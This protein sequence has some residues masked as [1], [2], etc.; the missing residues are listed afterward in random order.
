MPVIYNLI[1]F[2]HR[3]YDLTIFITRTISK[4]PSGVSPGIDCVSVC[5]NVQNHDSVARNA[6]AL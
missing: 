3:M 2:M 1:I 6:T 5:L 4:A